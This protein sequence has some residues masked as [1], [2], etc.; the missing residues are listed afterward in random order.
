MNGILI[1]SK[2]NHAKNISQKHLQ[3]FIDE[4]LAQDQLQNPNKSAAKPIPSLPQHMQYITYNVSTL[5]HTTPTCVPITYDKEEE[6]ND[7]PSK[8]NTPI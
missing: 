4:Q 7:P 3:K 5:I 1:G 8:E 2:H 6:N